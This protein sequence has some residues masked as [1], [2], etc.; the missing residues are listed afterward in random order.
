MLRCCMGMK[1]NRSLIAI[2]IT[3]LVMVLIGCGAEDGD[4]VVWIR[5]TVT[6]T[7]FPST[8]IVPTQIPTSIKTPTTTR[9]PESTLQ[10][11]PIL[12]GSPTYTQIPRSLMTTGPE[13]INDTGPW[14]VFFD[15][16]EKSIIAV[17]PDSTGYRTLISSISNPF[18]PELYGSS[19]NYLAFVAE[20]EELAVDYPFNLALVII[21]LPS[22]NIL[23]VLPLISQAEICNPRF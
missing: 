23:E 2:L 19:A 16:E 8:K 18:T 1:P 15:E 9:V 14:F 22:G 4:E 3:A 17:N 7:H 6:S 13:G 11:S 20:W 21:E 12:T 10:P 5:E